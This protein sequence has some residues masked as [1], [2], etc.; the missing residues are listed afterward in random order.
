MPAGWLS[1][2]HVAQQGLAPDPT[3]QGWSPHEPRADPARLRELAGPPRQVPHTPGRRSAVQ[4]RPLRPRVE[5]GELRLL[6]PGPVLVAVDVEGVSDAESGLGCPT[7]TS[8]EPAE[9]ARAERLQWWCEPLMSSFHQVRRHLDPQSAGH[10]SDR[11]NWQLGQQVLAWLDEPS[12]IERRV[13]QDRPRSEA[14]SAI[15]CR[16]G[17]RHPFVRGV[18]G[19]RR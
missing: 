10:G 14:A 4:Q 13:N 15:C 6:Q 19:R 3:Q 7:D 2:L 8:G 18:A 11:R 9:T 12:R 17:E 16:G 5:V 1:I